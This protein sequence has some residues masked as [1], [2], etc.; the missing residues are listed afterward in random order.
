MKKS[1]TLISG[2]VVLALVIVFLFR[3][4]GIFNPVTDLVAFVLRPIQGKVYIFSDSIDKYLEK[5]KSVE[6]LRKENDSLRDERDRLL[7][8]KSLLDS[9]MRDLVMTR[10]EEAFLTDKGYNGIVTRVIGRTSDSMIEEIIINSGTKKGVQVGFAVITQNGYLIGKVIEARES[11]AKVRLIIDRQCEIA[12]MVQNETNAPGIVTGQHGLSLAM[13]L[14]PQNESLT[15]D[16][17]VVTSGLESNI[18]QG[19]VIGTIS[20]T[21]INPG[22]IF[23]SAVVTSP[24]RFDHLQIVSVIIPQLSIDD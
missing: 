19:I 17:V 2:I 24:I 20:S 23:Q 1:Y 15:R 11:I 4:S 7:R 5:R 14:I 22:D 10:Q 8:D 3:T 6:D 13:E 16:Q 21:A 12:A 9:E 18:P